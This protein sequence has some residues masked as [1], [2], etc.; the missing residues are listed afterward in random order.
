MIVTRFKVNQ[1]CSWLDGIGGIIFMLTKSSKTE[2]NDSKES[3]KPK[4]PIFLALFG[5]FERV[6]ET[7]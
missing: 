7:R 6:I 2:R 5:L 1:S 4:K 3:T